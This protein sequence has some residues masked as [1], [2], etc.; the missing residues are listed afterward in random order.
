LALENLSPVY[1][2]IQ[3]SLDR[4]ESLKWTT[5]NRTIAI[6]GVLRSA[7]SLH[8]A[9]S[10]RQE[11]RQEFEDAIEAPLKTIEDV[12]CLLLQASLLESNDSKILFYSSNPARISRLTAAA[13]TYQKARP[14]FE[15]FRHL[16][17]CVTSGVKRDVN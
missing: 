17:D 2:V 7:R 3:S 1:D 12:G 8:E 4:L 15:R 10:E 5:S 11:I 13:A 16:A 6:Y 14:V 9:L